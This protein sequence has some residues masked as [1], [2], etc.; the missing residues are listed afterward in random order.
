MFRPISEQKRDKVRKK[1]IGSDLNKIIIGVI[2]RNQPRKAFDKVFEAFFYLVHGAYIECH[3]CGKIT[4]FPY[5]LLSHQVTPLTKCRKCH[6]NHCTQGTSRD[7]IRLYIHGSVVDCGWNLSDLQ[8]NYHLN[9]KVRVNNEIQVGA[10]ISEED[11]NEIYNAC[12]IF[13]LPTR[14]EGFGLPILEAMSAGIPIVVTD[15]SAHPEWARGCGEL[16]PP[17]AL[18]AEP[19]TNIRRAII[20]MDEYVGSLLKL[21]NNKE[22]RKEYGA[23]GREVAKS[24]DWEI[25]CKLWELLIDKA[26][27][28][29]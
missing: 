6:S 18:E 15:Y 8:N 25:I 24:M 29:E 17:I 5:N 11:L 13:T 1:I 14:G 28:K 26:L 9:G 16:V 7:D 10:G 20:D 2:A 19:P 21:I 3:Q 22:L 27:L 12:D 4:T 23:K